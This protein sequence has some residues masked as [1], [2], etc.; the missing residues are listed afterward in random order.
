MQSIEKQDGQAKLNVTIENRSPRDLTVLCL[1]QETISKDEHGAARHQGVEDN[2]EGLCTRGLELSPRRRER[3]VLTFTAPPDA[4]ASQ[5]A[6]H[7]HEKSLRRDAAFTIDG[8]KV[9]SGAVAAPVN[10]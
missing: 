5:F 6:L 4:S 8:L 1:L 7:Y 10:P 2:G 3:A 9:E